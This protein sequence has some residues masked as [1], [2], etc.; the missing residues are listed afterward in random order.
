ML[1]SRI[2]QTISLAGFEVATDISEIL[3]LTVGS[4]L[5]SNEIVSKIG[6]APR[7]M[8]GGYG[9]TRWIPVL[10]EL[11]RAL[12]SYV[13]WLRCR[14]V[15]SADMPLFFSREK[16]R[17]SNFRSLTR[18]T[19]RFIT[20]AAFSA[21]SIEN[22]GRLG[23]HTLQKTWAR[24]VYRNSGNDIMILKE[25]LKHSDVSVTQKYLEADEAD[26]MAAIVKCDFTWKTRVKSARNNLKSVN[27]T[28]AVDVVSVAWSCNIARMNQAGVE[29]AAADLDPAEWSELRVE[30]N[31]PHRFYG[32]LGCEGSLHVAGDLFGTI[33]RL[34]VAESDEVV[35]RSHFIHL[36]VE[37]EIAL[38]VVE[39][40][41]RAQ[42][43]PA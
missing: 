21:A 31:H 15:L 13:S 11:H 1:P 34:F 30:R 38:R 32:R 7:N 10:P 36:H 39:A 9:R 19:A 25:A 24:S 33:Q 35:L 26:V 6:V 20:H 42:P 3:S 43:C 5:R 2:G 18:E 29:D 41:P 37:R 8:T 40:R 22:D 4:V 27:L 17:A 14:F 12:D 16:D 23:T 28:N